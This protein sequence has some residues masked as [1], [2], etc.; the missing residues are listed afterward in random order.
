MRWTAK[1][2]V[3]T[4]HTVQ[5]SRDRDKSGTSAGLHSSAASMKENA[6]QSD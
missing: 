3:L 1:A 2:S 5:V 4:V 6:V